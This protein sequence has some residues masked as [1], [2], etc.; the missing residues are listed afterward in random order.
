MVFK[1]T[2]IAAALAATSAVG[3]GSVA[4]MAPIGRPTP[5]AYAAGGSEAGGF[6]RS[7][8]REVV[9]AESTLGSDDIANGAVGSAEL[10]DGAVTSAKVRD[11]SLTADDFAAGVLPAGVDG[12]AGADGANGADGATGASGT[13]GPAGPQGLAGPQGPQG[14]QGPA[15]AD[16][17]PGLRGLQ[18]LTGAQGAT[19]AAGA[20]GANGRRRRGRGRPVPAGLQGIQGLTGPAG[21]Q[22]ATGATGAQGPAG[23]DG[24]T[25]PQGPPGRRRDRP[26]GPAGPQGTPRKARKGRPARKARKGRQ[27]RQGSKGSGL[28]GAA[29]TSIAREV[30]RDGDQ[31]LTDIPAT[32][33]TMANMD[34]GSYVVFGKTTVTQTSGGNVQRP[35]SRCTLDAG[36]VSDYADSDLGKESQSITLSTHLVVS[37]GGTGTITL[38]CLN[39]NK[40]GT[41]V[42]RETK[43]IALKVDSLTADAV[44]G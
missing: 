17:P 33:A 21:P 43:I 6:R 8:V 35:Y 1:L 39:T 32:V 9:R 15:G 24:A 12:A 2:Q 13:R 37:F 26:H 41:F 7:T 23:A 10:A 4:V 40:N 31:D 42:A 27:A 36:S 14:P 18:G 28:P 34:P 38:S 20:D 3:A 29:G 25:G 22:G 16:G 44:L 19:G 11:G 5:A 30:H